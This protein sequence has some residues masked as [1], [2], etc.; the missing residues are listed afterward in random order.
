MPGGNGTAS[1]VQPRG[2]EPWEAEISLRTA[3]ASP[4]AP[5]HPP[6]A[7]PPPS[8]ELPE[9]TATPR[10]AQTPP[11]QRLDREPGRGCAHS[12]QPTANIRRDPGSRHRTTES[13]RVDRRHARWRERASFRSRAAP[14]CAAES[15]GREARVQDA[16]NR[17]VLTIPSPSRIVTRWSAAT[18]GNISFTPL[19][20]RTSTSATVTSPK[21]KW[22]RRS[23][24][25][26]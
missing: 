9:S 21:P 12:F 17:S 13:P 16:G 25:E 14:A 7:R 19:V 6:P 8:S 5:R 22:S 15:R 23:L 2:R 4:A 1:I 18:L 20:H 26:R 3:P 11:P 24:D 10:P